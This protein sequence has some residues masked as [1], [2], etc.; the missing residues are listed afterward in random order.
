MIR[1]N[2]VRSCGT[3]VSAAV[4][5]LVSS[6]WLAGGIGAQTAESAIAGSTLKSAGP[7]PFIVAPSIPLGY[8]P[9]SVATGDLRHSG[10]LDLVTTDY[11]SG[12][13]TVFLGAG[14]GK[15]AAGVE[16][17]AGP[18]PG[19]VLVADIN[20]D[21]RPDVVVANQSAGT[22]SVLL[23][24]GDGTLE[25]RQTYAVGFNPSFI[26]TGDFGGTGRVDVA[27][28]G[29]SR[30][31]LAILL[32][33]G[34]GGLEKAIS[35][36]LSK[37]PTS[38]SVADFNNDGHADLALAN[39]DGSVSILLGKGE[40]LFS[41]L[42]DV[43]VASGSLSSIATG[44]F[45]KDG[46]VDLIV[47]QPGQKLVSVLLGK[48]D[49]TFASPESYAV[50][51]EP[52]SAVVADVNGDAIS[53]LV[54][55]NNQSN[56][57]SVL[58][59]NGDGTF[60]KSRDFIAGNAPL[61]AVAGDF[62][63]SGHVDLAIINHSSQTVSIPGGNGD[64]TFKAA[65]SYVSGQQPASIASGILN[66]GKTQGLVVANYCGSDLTCASAGN[67]AVFLPDAS[68]AYRL[69]STYTVGAGP[70][71]V[72]LAD[73][74]G[75]KNLDIVV[76][77]R[78]DKT[79][80][81]LMGAGDN[82][83]RQ[84][85]TFP[86]AAAP[87]AIAVGDFNKDG[88]PDL[89]VLEDCGASTC[90][91]PGNVEI[92]LGAGAGTFQSLLTYPVGFSPISLAVGDINGDK[93]LDIVVA[94]RCGA[95]ASCLS[96]GSGT[97]LLGDGSGKF[98]AGTSLA[99]GNSP[100]S[101]A[102]GNL[103]GSRLDLIVSRSTDNTVAVLK[104][105]G[106]GTF[107]AA[108]PY[109]VGNKPGS[110]V[111]AD[112]NGDGKAD[113]AVANG[114]DSTASVL[115][116]KGDGTL[117]PATA[118]AV[119]NSPASLTVIGSATAGHASLATA[120]GASSS[121][122]GTEFTVLP[123]I[124]GGT[125]FA[126]FTLALTAGLDPSNVNDSVTFTATIT[127]DGTD[128]P[129]QNVEFT[130]GGTPISD[131]GGAT[132][133]PVTL[134]T[135]N[136]YTSV[137]I[138]STLTAG[139]GVSVTATYLPGDLVYADNQVDSSNLTQTVD[140]LSPTLTISA[141][142]AANLN[143]VVTLTATLSGAPF[144]PTSPSGT[145]SFTSN[146]SAIS[147][148][149]PATVN[150][151][152]GAATCATSALLAG[153]DV[154][155][156]S[157]PG[158][159]N[160][161]SATAATVNQ[162]I[163]QL[164]P[165]LTI[166]ATTAANLNTVVTLSATLSGAPFTPTSPSGTVSFTSN[167]SAIS[168]NSPA[169]VNST[170]GV[171]NC[172]TSALLAGTDVI[173]ASYPGDANFKTA[174]AATVNQTINQ[175][176]PTLALTPSPT[177]PITVGT[178]V[179]FTAQLGSAAFSPVAPTGTVIFKAN[180][181][182]ITCGSG[183]SP[184]VT[185]AGTAKCQT[186]ALVAP[187]DIITATYPGDGNFNAVGPIQI[188]ES[189]GTTAA[190]TIL[191][192]SNPSPDVNQSVT[193]TATVSAPSGTVVP[194]GSVTFTSGSTT[195]P[196]L[197]A[198]VTLTVGSTNSTAICNDSFTSVTAGTTI[199]A[200]YSGDTNFSSGTAAT[201]TEVVAVTSTGTGLSSVPS[202]STVNQQV[203]FTAVVTPVFTGA[204]APTGTVNFTNNGTPL[205]CSPVT[206][207]TSAGVTTAVCNVTFLSTSSNSVVARYNGDAN[208][209]LSNSAADLQ[210]VGKTATSTGV[211]SSLPSPPV[212]QTITF[213]AT[214][215]PAVTGSTNPSGT[216]KF[217]YVLNGGSSVTLCASA[218]VTTLSGVTTATCAQPLPSD[219]N[220]TISAAYSGDASFLTSTGTVPQPVGLATTTTALSA[221]P[222]TSTVNQ[223]VTFTATVTP[224]I[225]GSTNPTGNVTF[226]FTN[227]SVT[228]PVNLCVPKAVSTSAG[229]T[230]ATCV[231]SLPG[232]AADTIN[233]TY[234]G[235]TNFGSS[236]GTA[237]QTVNQTA[238]T[239]AVTASTSSPTVNQAITFTATINPTIAP[240]AGSTNPSGKVTFTYTLGTGSPVT[241]CASAAVSTTA[242]VTTATCSTSLPTDGSYTISAAYTG[243]ANFIASTGALPESVG[244]TATTTTVVS[245]LTTSVVNQVSTYT[246]TIA[247]VVPGSTNPKGSVT[248]TYSLNGGAAVNLN[249]TVSQ[250]V[251]V[252]TLGTVT[253]AACTAPLPTK[254]SYVIKATYSGDSNFAASV[255]TT[256]PQTVNQASTATTVVSS[257]PSAAVNQAVIFTATITPAIA[258]PTSPTG[259]VT[260]TSTLSGGSPVNLNC[261]SA[262]PI[263]VSTTSGITT[264][265]C[266]AS[267]SAGGSY[268][269]TATYSGDTNF[270]SP[271]VGTVVQPVGLTAT[272]TAVVSSLSP[273]F[274]NEAVSFTATVKSTIS[275]STNPSG[276]VAFTYVFSGGVPVTL[277]A[278]A[279]VTQSTGVASCKVPLPSAGT[280]AI[281]AT[282][283]GDTNFA[284]STNLNST[285]ASPLTQT[286]NQ[287]VTTV[288]LTSVPANSS[289]VNQS[290]TFTATIN[291][292]N[293]GAPTYTGT[294]EPT[295]TV[296]FT[297]T[298]TSTTLCTINVSSA[299]TVP[300]CSFAFTSP[301]ANTI[302]ATYSGDLN[303]PKTTSAVVTQTVSQSPSTT[304]VV[305]SNANP[306]VNQPMTFTA[307]VAPT[308]F[309]GSVFPTG[310]VTF[311]YTLNGAAP[312]T[313]CGS[314]KVATLGTVT[315]ALCTAP[316]P[317][318]APAK[319]P[320]TITATYSGD[321]NFISGAGTTTQIVAGTNTAT[322][323]IAS[324]SPSAVN[325]QVTF[326]A[327]VTPA[328]VGSIVPTGSVTFTYS[329][330][331]GSAVNLS[332]KPVQPVSVGTVGTGSAAVT[333]A[334][335]TAPLP[336]AGSYT[337]TASYSG[338][339]NFGA[340]SNSSTPLTQTVSPANLTLAV[341]SSTAASASALQATSLVNQ[342]LQFT[343]TLV[344]PFSAVATP[345][346]TVTFNDTL[347]GST[348]CS[349][350]SVLPVS[351]LTFKA[352]CNP[353]A[354]TPWVAATHSITATY[355]GGDANFP[356][357]TS[358]VFKQVVTAAPA[359]ATVVS[360]MSISVA[361]QTVT[362]TAMITP[363]MTGPVLPTGT[364][365][366]ATSG[367]WA[368]SAPC[369]TVQVNPI[370]SGTG[371][372]TATAIC[373]VQFPV[374]AQ[375]QT[376]TVTYVNDPNFS[377]NSSSVSQTIQNFTIANSVTSTLAPTSS[378]GP[379]IL[380]QGYSTATTSAP[381]TDPFN[382]TKVQ[383]VVT[384]TGGFTDTLGLTCKVTNSITNA[385]ATNP[386]CT[387]SATAAGANSTALT[388]T[389]TSP[390][391]TTSPTPIGEY[392]VTLTADD[393]ANPALSNS[394]ALTVFIVGEANLLSLAQG[395]SGQENVSFNTFAAPA[396]DTFTSVACG[397]VVPLVNGV[398]GTPLTSPGI[399]CTSHIPAA[400]IPIISG[401]T[402]TVAVT[403]SPSSTKT[404]ELRQSN[405]VS[406]AAFLG[407]PL[408]ALMGWVGSRKSPR[409]N[410]FRFL[411]LILLLVGVSYASG[412]GGN[413]TSSST[414][415]ST[416][417]AAGNYLVQVVGTDQNSVSYYAVIPLDVSAN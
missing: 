336:A 326:T 158:D 404:A 150:A 210:P 262:Q 108:V 62:Y 316:L 259:T 377:A 244:V 292:V 183:S 177:G 254:G 151:T 80:T 280:Y 293:T 123:E 197:C 337:V 71:S 278:T 265:V 359:T 18:E 51:H 253:T 226:T 231:A 86:L 98:K 121:G 116:G 390:P 101:I 109:R 272:T 387:V 147:C 214:V 42:A 139:T 30:N 135:V 393:N 347:T 334:Q 340:S 370:T 373:T 35:R 289:V 304:T 40:G 118:I 213:T 64:G 357:T 103:T 97:V 413:F 372:G 4:V 257:V 81:V 219:G 246:A 168:C 395:A 216:V 77:N 27:V 398:P 277:C 274:V 223:S 75:D 107:Q 290:V 164:S 412:C 137:C 192:S 76:A 21:G 283:S 132:G 247:P 302:T 180:G 255:G 89:A 28:A 178:S 397:T 388:Y 52:V 72:A 47:T 24:K 167:G 67:V 352:V 129:T 311:S 190:N 153:T 61:A 220:Y 106:D 160:F 124:S 396:S 327:T 309:T 91:E 142:T 403:I 312:V 8:A 406:M 149:S 385:V 285:P 58:D 229:K 268:T 217:S 270:T 367:L 382:P 330:N 402:T 111:V 221:V 172:A 249:C 125:D 157:Y 57:F 300:P 332:C 199:F 368:P 416:G 87:V 408:L 245:S 379:V 114:S 50:G 225:S 218:G 38:L 184:T 333:T 17:A 366:F 9:S 74:K 122:V 339:A 33:N 85:A 378:S 346:S 208:F 69:S 295:G 294:T 267:L 205:A 248:F 82:T 200:N 381:G 96:A 321:T 415:T 389:V 46:K 102:L 282:Y 228:T 37:T 209:T 411:G 315:T 128:A 204:A 238:T 44:D 179:T 162:T 16:Y 104:G 34:N 95:E 343:A 20:G 355:N 5:F 12:N 25:A 195:G 417:I 401:G 328:V 233:A 26:V 291:P 159:N 318:Q 94:N 350:V 43:N 212:N 235:D 338:D 191:A 211:V 227:S 53:D 224:T 11:A 298:L 375:S 56:T 186:S 185:A 170:T 240:F 3:F 22:I 79:V 386:T 239:T 99:L 70:V 1:Y 78:L 92:L 188:A 83:F 7:A 392:T 303:F 310:T 263:S 237:A 344:L 409:R 88:K 264:A 140:Q 84:P 376:I 175:L 6:A 400:G 119:G 364:F 173:G 261:T 331:G 187:A 127:G 90:T 176:S 353:P 383:M 130:Y 138:T 414:T 29:T 271:A 266:T 329:L 296:T 234:A 73:L 163:N 384:S 145:V 410:F 260:F 354:T 394:S 306:S 141:T 252:S 301:A 369:P 288:G 251:T 356:G 361:T 348:L 317:S 203:A 284:G 15:F 279:G 243:D 166:S 407:I 169:T 319:A 322:T 371:S 181:N 161:A 202:S 308:T 196:Q 342:P 39:T 120:N 193:F 362:F 314:V 313:L 146:G 126:T 305:S 324:P 230:T 345:T 115:F 49:G 189:V 55:I 131:C 241:L 325:Q 68:G 232:A 281:T 65:R 207:A 156:A 174:T 391:S 273:S 143:T 136:T 152:T 297:D 258:G 405:A 117:Q 299:G 144:T 165:T 155:G 307:T 133:E 351:A 363:T 63:G 365:Q 45:N 23:G 66:G 110:L 10:K 148:N 380:T 19:S 54:V 360:S 269:I 93:N 335:C 215:T 36:S 14:Q 13:I 59:G 31:L 374:T 60:A 236:S 154:I 256:T 182:P 201:R 320:Y 32:N 194:T 171:A 275:G 48:G 323:V 112:F 250:P 222:S 113:V 341:I 287:P 100:S 358:P 134:S 399:T 2:S 286:V 242:E 41:A 349:D 198:P 206:V 105:N 276:S